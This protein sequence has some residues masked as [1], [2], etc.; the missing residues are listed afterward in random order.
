MAHSQDFTERIRKYIIPKIGAVFQ[1]LNDISG[2]ALYAESKS[3]RTEFVGRVDMGEEEFEKVL[4]DMGFERNPFAS[5]KDRLDTTEG[6]EGSFRKIYPDEHPEWQLHTVIYD[7][8]DINN[9][10]SGECF[11]YSHWEYRWDTHPW[12]HYL[13]KDFSAAKGVKKMKHLLDTH[14]IQYELVQP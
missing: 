11:V 13:A 10:E 3:R 4:H 8:S 7:G 14:G 6:E 9:A 12:K 1:V 5:L 2:S